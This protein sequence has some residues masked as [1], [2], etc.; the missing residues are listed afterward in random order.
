MMPA[1]LEAAMIETLEDVVS[2]STILEQ[3][4]I[5]LPGSSAH[6][7]HQLGSPS[8]LRAFATGETD[9]GSPNVTLGTAPPYPFS[10]RGT[11][12]TLCVTKCRLEAPV[13][14]LSRGS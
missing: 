5:E 11:A 13:K 10:T 7:Q 3:H 12:G 6:A 8:R 9:F 1:E 4:L 2:R 14:P